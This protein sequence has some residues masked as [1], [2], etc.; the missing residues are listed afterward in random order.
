[1]LTF[2]DPKSR[3]REVHYVNIVSHKQGWKKS[4]FFRKNPKNRFNRLNGFL[5]DFYFLI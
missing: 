2:A 4:R 3:L 5:C 1:M